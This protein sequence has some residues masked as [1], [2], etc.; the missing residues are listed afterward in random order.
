MSLTLERSVK[1][2]LMIVL[3]MAALAMLPAVAEAQG[4]VD[5]GPSDASVNRV[6]TH[7][8][9]NPGDSLWSISQERLGPEATPQQVLMQVQRTYALNQNTIGTDPNLI[10]PGQKL[11]L[12]R[13]G[14]PAIARQVQ[15]TSEPAGKARTNA[16]AKP[17][18]ETASKKASS[19]PVPDTMPASQKSP[20]QLPAIAHAPT[21][22]P[23]SE[24][25]LA[26][27]WQTRLLSGAYNHG[28]QLLGVLLILLSLSAGFLMARKLPLK[29]DIRERARWQIMSEVYRR[30]Y[31][32]A[33]SN[34]GYLENLRRHSLRNGRAPRVLQDTVPS[35][36]NRL[37]LIGLVGAVSIKRRLRTKR[38]SLARGSRLR[39]PS[40]NGLSGAR[41]PEI[42]RYQ[43][44]TRE[45][46]HRKTF[47]QEQRSRGGRR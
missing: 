7:L 8:V 15:S 19:R 35:A 30:S 33:S 36:K 11:S 47:L 14:K 38:A 32:D 17:S 37:D 39:I 18:S 34:A 31:A 40:R 20:R 2:L 3:W 42:R 12:P 24:L 25:A 21:P 16:V 28:R 4:R 41:T 1:T 13:L 29:R 6:P 10:L 46:R 23:L 45:G 9:V 27:P 22:A 44:I 43:R 5:D 26:A